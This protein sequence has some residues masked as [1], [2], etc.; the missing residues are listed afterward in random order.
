MQ[1]KSSVDGRSIFGPKPKKV[2][3]SQNIRFNNDHHLSRKYKSL[4]PYARQA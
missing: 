2:I 3:A 4:S 1:K